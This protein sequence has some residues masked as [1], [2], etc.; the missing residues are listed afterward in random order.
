MLQDMLQDN[1]LI[2]L[3]MLSFLT[4]AGMPLNGYSTVRESLCSAPM[5]FLTIE[6][7]LFNRSLSEELN[8]RR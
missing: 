8:E 2:A 5:A 3:F 6:Q 4:G 7:G 1:S